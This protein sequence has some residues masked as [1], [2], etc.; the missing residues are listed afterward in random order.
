M[1]VRAILGLLTLNALFLAVG[2]SLVWALCGWTSRLGY[3]RLAGLAYLLGVAALGIIWTLLLVL[4]IPFGVVTILVSAGLVSGAALIV[5]YRIGREQPERRA[6]MRFTWVSLVSATGIALAGT[7]LE[8]LFRA[9]RLQGLY[10]FDGWAFWIPKAKA[11]YYFGGLD[12]QFF[13]ELPGPTYPPLVP[14]LDAA[15]FH[16]MGSADVVSLHLQYWFFVVGF[17][18]AVVGL[19][20]DRVPAWILWPF[21]VLTLVMPRASEHLFTP[22]ADFLLDFFVCAAAVLLALWLA[23]RESWELIAGS[24]LLGAAVLTKREGVLLAVILFVGLAVASLDRR[25]FALPRIAL[26]A[27]LVAAVGIPWRLWYADRGIGGEA[28]TQLDLDRVKEAVR[29]SLVVFF[30]SSLWSIITTIVVAAVVF[31]AIWG[32][33]RLAL[34]FGLVLGLTMLGGAWITA[35]YEE[36]PITANEAL[37]PIVRYSAAGVIVSGAAIPLLLASVWAREEARV[38]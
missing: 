17:V 8:A 20:W 27:A 33:R 25:R 26:A 22:Q 15:A 29:L 18:C 3:A 28:P 16:A 35:S 5:A 13:T 11:I 2:S 7:F 32:S 1:T 10:A 9:A 23:E 38:R 14:I 19:L 31:A 24:A 30:D 34:F 12:A 21:V 37:N 36:L 6:V 4:G